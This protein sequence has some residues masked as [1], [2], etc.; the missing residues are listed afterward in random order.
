MKIPPLHPTVR[1]IQDL[2]R[3][4]S[5]FTDMAPRKL[6]QLAV[7]IEIPSWLTGTEEAC[8][9]ASAAKSIFGPRVR[10]E[11]PPSSA[12]SAAG[13]ELCRISYDA[14]ECTG[15]GQIMT[16]EYD[17]NLAVA[18]VMQTPLSDWFANPITFSAVTGLP[19]QA[20]IEWIN[21]FIDSQRP[22]QLMLVG[23]DAD[24]S[25]FADTLAES[26]AAS[27]LEDRS[28]LPPH[29]ILASGAALAA[30]VGLESQVDDCGELA[31]CIDL[32]RK[33]DAIA[34]TYRPLKPSTWPAT[35]PGHVEF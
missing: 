28:P 1:L 14:F 22:D 4:L 30:K 31:E 33:A 6:S 3:A 35:G 19:S 15:P 17:G 7:G 29:H 11:S 34:G 21:T 24:D 32:R 16:L 25:S 2:M 27:Y 23:P 5:P 9:I 20:M 12:Y 18:S 8:H 26:R 13:Y 10:F